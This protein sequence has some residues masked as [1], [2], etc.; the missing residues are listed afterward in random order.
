VSF[1]EGGDAACWA[2]DFERHDI[3][4]RVDVEH[5]V[6]T[7]YRAAAMD[8]LLGPVFSA[9]HVDWTHHIPLVT[10][11]WMWQLFAQRGYEGNPLR[12]HEPAHERTPFTTAHFARWL[13]LFTE[14]TDERFTGPTAELAKARARKMAGALQRLLGDVSAPGADAIEVPLTSRPSTPPGQ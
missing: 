8:D 7:F 3:A 14:T 6:R 12:A 5:L 1:D 10:D 13:E 4:T 9:A 2:R 11:F